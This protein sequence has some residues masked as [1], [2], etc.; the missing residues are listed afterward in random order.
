M[1]VYVD[2]MYRSPMGQYGRMKMSHM[3]ADTHDELMA[4]AERI[5]LN[6]SWLQDAGT[7]REHFDVSMTK[8][9]E[10]IAAGALTVSMREL[11][12]LMR[13]CVTE[14]FYGEPP[15]LVPAR[16][17]NRALPGEE[18]CQECEWASLRAEQEAVYRSGLR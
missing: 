6:P 17:P 1:A 9:R 10:A 18:L 2:D 8:R 15:D 11:V 4:M 12:G 7:R 13:R 16:C 3:A 5:G 14:D